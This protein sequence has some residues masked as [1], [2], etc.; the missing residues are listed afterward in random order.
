MLTSTELLILAA[1]GGAVCT[2]ITIFVW[3]RVRTKDSPVPGGSRSGVNNE[4]ALGPLELQAFFD[5]VTDH[6]CVIDREYRIHQA[7]KS[8]AAL[9]GRPIEE[10]I[11]KK[12]YT[13]LWHSETPCEECPARDTFVN[14]EA[15]LR[16]KAVLHL[17][18]KPLHLEQST[19]P[20][21]E[22]NGHLV[23]VIEY[24]RDMTEEAHLLDQLMRSERFAGIG[25]LTT[26][27]AHEMNNALSGIAGTASNLLTMPEKFGLN[28]KAVNRIFSIM[29]AASRATGVMKNLLQFSSPHQEETRMMVNVKQLVRKIIKSVC[30]QE[31]PDIERLVVFDEAIPPIR[32]DISKIELVFMNV[33]TNSIRSIMLMQHRC[34]R[35]SRPFKGSIT[36][37]GVLQQDDVVVAVT[38]NGIGIPEN[39][40]PKIFNPFFSTW[41]EGKGT[42]LGLSTALHVV[43]EHGGRISFDSVSGLTTFSILLPIDR[44][45]PL[46][47][48][49]T[50]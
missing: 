24:V 29:D 19:Y 22:G 16:K 33:I 35:D 32:V 1:L 13:I 21:Y 26:G 17:A 45:N 40:R 34:E 47:A 28:E 8:Y 20:V 15:V 9:V 2:V 30:A 10:I 41:P 42:G 38:D 44:K 11:G 31:A 18:E 50:Q 49:T 39:I 23:R 36:V 48:G 3:A 27:I 14:G 12:C 43:E 25:A 4:A 46:N 5:S 6:I 7:N 37:T